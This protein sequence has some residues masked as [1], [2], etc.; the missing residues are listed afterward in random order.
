MKS[1]IKKLII[2]IILVLIIIN[3]VNILEVRAFDT[4]FWEPEDLD[5]NENGEYLTLVNKIISYFKI[6][7]AGIAIIALMILGIKYLFRKSR[8]KS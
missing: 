4:G 3:V 2:T 5:L 7:G 1:K 6:I 8:R